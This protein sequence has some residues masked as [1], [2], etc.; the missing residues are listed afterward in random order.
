MKVQPLPLSLS[1]TSRACD[2]GYRA[3]A[4]VADVAAQIGAAYRIVGGHMVT[5]LVAACGVSDQ[6]PM[7][8]TVD[9]DFAALPEVVG[10]PDLAGALRQ[11]G[12]VQREASNR[13]RRE[14]RDAHGS[15]DLV[16]DIL[17]PSY[18]G[19]ILHNRQHGD[20]FVDEI[21]GLA[22]ALNRPATIVDLRVRLT[23]GEE[24]AARLALPDLAAALCI[25]AL[26]Y[27]GRYADKDAVDLWRLV[28]AAHAA[29]LRAE[30]WPTG[31]TGRDAGAVLR[32]FFGGPASAGLKQVSR[33]RS[34]R[35]RMRALVHA[36][37]PPARGPGS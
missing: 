17:A 5:L 4:D 29:G 11:R 15:L 23:G 33:Q 34:D 16:V 10:N 28:S 18:L 9:A 3:L 19:R 21:P 20:L 1:S 14:H 7:R 24:T 12:Y 32:R 13:F 25:K 30:S 8:E 37:V 27:R 2:A 26:A 22:F 36:V 31:V 6:V 35:T